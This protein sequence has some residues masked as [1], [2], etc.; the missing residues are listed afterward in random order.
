MA[1]TRSFRP[2]NF[3]AG[4]QSDF[5]TP[6][7]LES[8]QPQP[9][10]VLVSCHSQKQEP[11]PLDWTIFRL[12]LICTNSFKEFIL[13]QN[14]WHSLLDSA[15]KELSVAIF[16]TA[17]TYLG[18]SHCLR[19]SLISTWKS[20]LLLLPSFLTSEGSI[21][22]VLLGAAVCM[23]G[24]R[25]SLALPC[26]CMWGSHYNRLQN[27]WAHNYQM[28]H[29]RSGFQVPFQH[30]YGWCWVD[31]FEFVRERHSENVSFNK[32]RPKNPIFCSSV[33]SQYNKHLVI[34]TM[35]CNTPYKFVYTNSDYA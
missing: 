26:I 28:E 22:I 15:P 33:W 21:Q 11:S 10:G 13:H 24:L 14:W 16:G 25:R 27:F 32:A 4:D 1:S 3:F 29:I 6:T 12:I 17:L 7:S 2:A 19:A 31:N 9:K 20:T 5:P 8:N 35:N 34:E 18:D 23:Y 30:S